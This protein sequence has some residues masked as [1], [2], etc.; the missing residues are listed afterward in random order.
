MDSKKTLNFDALLQ[1]LADMYDSAMEFLPK[2]FVGLILL[3]AGWI[4]AKFIKR[5]TKKALLKIGAEK[6][7]NK[8][9]LDTSLSRLNP[10]WTLSG[11][12][13]QLL[14]Y[15]IML[16]FVVAISDLLGLNAVKEAILHFLS[17]IPVFAIALTI[18]VLG[19]YIAKIIQK[20]VY[21]ATNSIGI[22]GA[23]VIGNLVFYVLMIFITLTALQQVGLNTD[24]ISNNITVII[25]AILLAF[26]IAYGIAA[27][28]IVQNMLSSYYGKGKF[29]I[30]QRIRVLDVEGEIVKIDSI[31]VS[32]KSG[33]S[34]VVLPSKVL[35]E[36]KVEI[37]H[38]ND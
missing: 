32:I 16:M 38:S 25:A 27:R 28:G 35:L 9:E 8:L 13:A 19:Y 20:A 1:S 10:D 24:L 18:F 22:S 31:S 29:E 37:I 11:M 5:I 7:S 21:T 30:G 36:N 33:D 23:K 14:Y 3:L 15:V 17:L 12:I 4:L 34:V 26:A 6:L 2:I